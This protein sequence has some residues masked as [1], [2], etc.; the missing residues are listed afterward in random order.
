VGFAIIA[1]ELFTARLSPPTLICAVV[2][3]EA[4]IAVVLKYRS[5]LPRRRKLYDE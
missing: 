4:M 5:L 3:L 2:G 1:V